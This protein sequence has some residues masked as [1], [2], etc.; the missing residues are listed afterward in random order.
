ML[1][2]QRKQQAKGDGKSRKKKYLI[3]IKR[4]F[5]AFRTFLLLLMALHFF[6]FFKKQ[7]RKRK[8]KKAKAKLIKNSSS[9]Y[10]RF[11]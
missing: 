2:D 6:F 5:L 8:E 7:A 1:H 3:Q 9:T 4:D 10:I 11:V